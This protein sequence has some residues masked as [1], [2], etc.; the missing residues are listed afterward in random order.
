MDE[1]NEIK[2][3]FVFSFL[4]IVPK[5]LKV[6]F[7][8]RSRPFK[9]ISFYD[10]IISTCHSPESSWLFL[11]FFPLLKKYT[12]YV[13]F[14]AL[15]WKEMNPIWIMVHNDK[16]IK[17]NIFYT[18]MCVSI[19]TKDIIIYNTKYKKMF[20]RRGTSH[21]CRQEN[22]ENNRKLHSEV[23]FLARFSSLRLAHHHY[24]I[25]T[26]SRTTQENERILY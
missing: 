25:F 7:T 19:S 6:S 12:T 17:E 13:C 11:R 20:A 24:I 8:E 18:Y 23:I 4:F 14:D 5:I 15:F 16:N 21:F 9:L 3:P 1:R 2:R 22:Q 10:W 26:V